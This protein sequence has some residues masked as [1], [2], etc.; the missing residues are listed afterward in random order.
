MIENRAYL[1]VEHYLYWKIDIIFVRVKLDLMGKK[2]R[3]ICA[4][5]AALLTASSAMAQGYSIYEDTQMDMLQRQMYRV[6]EKSLHPSLRSYSLDELNKVFDVD[7]VLYAGFDKPGEAS[8]TF[9]QLC[10]NLLWD[11]F[12]Q[13]KGDDYYV[14]L[15]PMFDFRVGKADG[16]TTFLNSRAF[17]VN[18][19]LGKNFWFYMDLSENQMITTDYETEFYDQHMMGNCPVVSG[20]ASSKH[21]GESTKYDYDWEEANGYVAFRIGKYLDFQIGKS[22]TFIGDGYRSLLLSDFAPSYPM[23]KMNATFGPVKYMYMMSQLRTLRKDDFTENKAKIYPKYSFTHYLDVNLGKRVAIGLFENVTQCSW[24]ESGDHRGVD[25]DYVNPFVVFMPGEFAAGSPDKMLIGMNGLLKIDHWLN[26]YGQF[27][28]NE[29]RLKELTSGNNWWANKYGFLFG[30]K[31]IDLFNIDGW[32]MQFEMSQVRPYTYSQYTGMANYTH[33][34]MPLA[35]PLGANFREVLGIMQYRHNRI[36]LRGQ[37]N[38]AKHGEDI[39]YKNDHIS[40]GGDPTKPSNDRPG[41]Y[42]NVM[43]QGRET[44]IKYLE[45]EFAWLINPRTRLNAAITFS[46]RQRTNDVVD[47]ASKHINFALRWGLKSWHHDY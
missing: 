37:F 5:G 6:G 34:T 38:I 46:Y 35:H 3:H 12:V 45:G 2:I 40:Y 1:S 27:V 33:M 21:R 42:G 11:D 13:I 22:K 4:I 19:N 17:Y 24:R 10:Q 30:F 28:L 15:N 20:R 32:D 31:S 25:W 9:R 41:N 44:D 14:A 16:K 47:E 8:N 43:F 7:S 39:D 26:L 29:F 36:Y 23:F 18:G